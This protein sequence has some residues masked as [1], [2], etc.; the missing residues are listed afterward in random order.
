VIDII[1]EL[2]TYSV[3]LTIVDPWA[4][5]AEVEHEYGIKTQIDLPKETKFDA[6]ILA[7]GHKEFKEINITDFL[8]SEIF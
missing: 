4:S 2:N 5:P 1:N 6:I 8:N 3:N 7:V